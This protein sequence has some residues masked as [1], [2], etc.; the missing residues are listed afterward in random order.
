MVS[1][2]RIFTASN[3]LGSQAIEP[4]KHQAIEIGD[5]D[6]LGC[7]T[8]QH[9]G[10]MPK[11]ENF[12]LQRCARPEQPRH[13]VPDQ[14]EEIAQPFWVYGRDRGQHRLAG[15]DLEAVADLDDRPFIAPLSV[16]CQS[17]DGEPSVSYR[18]ALSK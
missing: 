6:P 9:I 7:S 8:P 16:C 17:Q 13:C 4:R 14:L 18:Q 11:G 5:G 10:A 2:L 12:G 15:P 1:G 3:N